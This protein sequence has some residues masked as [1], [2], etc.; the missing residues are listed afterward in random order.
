MNYTPE[1][2][3]ILVPVTLGSGD[4]IAVKQAMDFQRVYGCEILLLHVI[5]DPSLVIKIIHREKYKNELEQKKSELQKFAASFYGGSIPE[6]L[7]MKVER[8]GVV[9]T[10]HR[11]AEECNCDLIIVKRENSEDG[12]FRLQNNENADKLISGSACPVLTIPGVVSEQGIKDILIPVDI[13][14]KI[15][16]KIAWVKYLA[17]RFNARVH[18]VSVLDLDIAPLKSLAYRKALK[19]EKSMKDAG[20]EANVNLLK[21]KRNTMHHAILSHIETI[22]PDFVLMMTHQESILYDNYIGKFANEVIHKS[23]SPV[24]SLVPRTE[25]LMTSFM[26]SLVYTKNN[27]V[28]T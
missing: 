2:K 7:S 25:T 19:I 3:K 11:A 5:M 8:G 23:K 21:A 15:A 9:Q 20:L 12:L 1:I 27:K 18:I 10:I 14:K 26:D 16:I 13:T 17:A 6:F 4:A 22:N 24:F 28:L